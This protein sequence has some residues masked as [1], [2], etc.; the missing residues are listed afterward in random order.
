[1]RYKDITAGADKYFIIL[2]YDVFKTGIS[3]NVSA[4]LIAPIFMQGHYS[5]YLSCPSP[6]EHPHPPGKLSLL[7]LR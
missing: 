4:H 6:V 5:N 3:T 2:G 7:R 1:M